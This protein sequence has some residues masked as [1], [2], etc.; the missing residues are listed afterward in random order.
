M[1]VLQVLCRQRALVT[2]FVRGEARLFVR[3]GQ[4]GSRGFFGKAKEKKTATTEASSVLL[5]DLELRFAV[6][7]CGC[8]YL[9]LGNQLRSTRTTNSPLSLMSSHGLRLGGVSLPSSFIICVHFDH[10]LL[11]AT[12]RASGRIFFRRIRVRLI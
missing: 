5:R 10:A 9:P 1:V 12:E 11:S 7:G 4:A 3:D 6:V 8:E 2:C